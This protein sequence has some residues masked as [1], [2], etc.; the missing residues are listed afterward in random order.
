MKRVSPKIAALALL[1]IAAAGF[2]S[3]NFSKHMD[4]LQSV[5]VNAEVDTSKCDFKT[6]DGFTASKLYLNGYADFYLHLLPEGADGRVEVWA[7]PKVME[8]LVVG[9]SDDELKVDFQ[10]KSLKNEQGKPNEPKS[11]VH[12]Y[13]PSLTAIEALCIGHLELGSLQ[14][15]SALEMKLS[16]MVDVK[17]DT[18]RCSKFTFE[19]EGMDNMKILAL[20]ADTL[21]GSLEGIGNLKISGLQARWINCQSEGMGDMVLSGTTEGGIIKANGIGDIDATGLRSTAPLQISSNG[22][23]KVK[24]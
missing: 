17:I 8:K 22:L 3:C 18:L 12:I 19:F 10:S 13:I 20:A 15:P 24:K 16:G 1:V 11:L 7:E 9:Q 6:F 21:Q 23:G 14:L 5:I 2:A 4:R